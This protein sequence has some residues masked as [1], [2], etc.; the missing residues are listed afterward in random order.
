MG[1]S[2]VY[3]WRVS[4]ETKAALEHEARRAGLSLAEL[5]KRI[6]VDWLEERRSENGTESAEQRRLHAQ[7]AKLFGAIAGGDPRRSARSREIV[8]ERLARRRGYR[9]VVGRGKP[10]SSL[11]AKRTA[12]P[13]LPKGRESRRP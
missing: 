8:R 9:P 2:E 10:P 12:K 7:A 4:P 1:K 13:V 6:S 11:R 3:S 5:L